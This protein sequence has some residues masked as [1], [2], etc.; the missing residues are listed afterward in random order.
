MGNGHYLG[1]WLHCLRAYLLLYKYIQQV[2][3]LVVLLHQ[4]S[5]NQILYLRVLSVILLYFQLI[6]VYTLVQVYLEFL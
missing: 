3:D 5:L 2:L 1:D 6:P 4:L